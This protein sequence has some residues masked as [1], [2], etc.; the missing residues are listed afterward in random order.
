MQKPSKNFKEIQFSKF[1][2]KLFPSHIELA[3]DLGI[4]LNS[5]IFSQVFKCK[6]ENYSEAVGVII[7]RK[8]EQ[9]SY[10]M[11]PM[12]LIESKSE[13]EKHTKWI[14][15]VSKS[16]IGFQNMEYL[17]QYTN[18]KAYNFSSYDEAMILLES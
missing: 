15:M 13:I 8:N 1:K 9:H 3:F 11:D 6:I 5:E 2:L 16:G 18:V 14:A 17:K 10:S 7:I 12:F 4:N